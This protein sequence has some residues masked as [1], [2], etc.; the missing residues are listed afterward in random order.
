M[1]RQVPRTAFDH[2]L[3]K[4][5]V[6]HALVQ[7]D[8][9]YNDIPSSLATLLLVDGSPD[10]LQGAYNSIKCGLSPWEPSPRS[11]ADEESKKRF[12]GDVRFQRAYMTYFSMEHIRVAGNAKSLVISQVFSGEKPLICGLFSGIGHPLT[13]LADGIELR[14]AIL[15]MESLTLCAVDWM[16]PVYEFL[17]HPQL[18]L[19]PD[20][21]MSPEDILGR[22]AHDGHLSGIMKAGPGFHGI[23][24]VFASSNAKAALVQYVRYLDTRDPNVLL[25]QLSAL[26]VLLLAATHKPSQ[27]AFDLYLSRLP[28]CVNSIRVILENWAEG[29]SHMILV[30]GLWLIMLLTYV[31]QLRPVIDGKLLVSKEL[32]EE[33]S[34]WEAVFEQVLGQG[35]ADGKHCDPSL[36]RSLRSLREISNAYSAVHG[37][38]YFHAAWKLVRQWQGWTGLGVEREVMLNI[39]L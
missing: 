3:A 4:S 23:S 24:Q 9:R 17:T 16:E 32:V 14:S 2:L 34:G 15:V 6:Q 27:P 33:T 20:A 31:T 29:D 8:G 28:T 38:V 7:P 22:V 26:S 18:M 1:A 36:L 37:R 5:H 39:R 35:S 11:I 13:L 19:A 10:H 12:L 25:Q 30:R 21:Y